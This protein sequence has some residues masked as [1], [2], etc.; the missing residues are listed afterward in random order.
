LYGGR[1][2]L[3]WAAALAGRWRGARYGSAALYKGV[4]GGVIVHSVVTGP[5]DEKFEI[6]SAC[7]ENRYG[8]VPTYRTDKMQ[9]T[10]IFKI[11][12]LKFVLNKTPICGL[13]SKGQSHEINNGL[14]VCT[15]QLE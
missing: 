13:I 6:I 12:N 5:L 1:G 15:I 4:E 14:K 11:T 10:S 7:T 9:D 8:T 3:F 2:P